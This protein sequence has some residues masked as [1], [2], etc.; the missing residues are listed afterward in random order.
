MQ[1]PTLP[2]TPE[3]NRFGGLARKLLLVKAE[4]D[5]LEAENGA[6]ETSR[7][8]RRRLRVKDDESANLLDE[9]GPGVP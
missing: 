8:T 1:T 7:S 2:N 3:I 6:V 4:L 5:A 9:V